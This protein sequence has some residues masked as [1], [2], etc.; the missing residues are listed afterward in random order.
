M[1]IGHLPAGYLAG[2]A[3]KTLGASQALFLGIILGAVLPDVDMLWFHLVDHGST[4]HHNYLPHRPIVWAVT[5]FIG[6]TARNRTITGIG[7]GA[8]LH[9]ALDSIAGQITWGWPF[10]E[11]ATTLVTVQPTHS[12]WILSFMAHWTFQVEIAITLVAAILFWRANIR[13]TPS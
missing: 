4:H 12:H 1:I 3:A 11:H 7:L 9:M 6:L 8:L 5:L 10:F 13:R 2:R